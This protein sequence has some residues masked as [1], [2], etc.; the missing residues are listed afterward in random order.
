MANRQLSKKETEELF[1]PLYQ[2]VTTRLQELSGNDAGLLWALRRKLAKSLIYDE[3]GTPMQRRRLKLLK[4]EEQQG[5]CAV[6][7]ESLPERDAILDRFEAMRGYTLENTRVLCRDCDL[8]I[9]TERN[10]S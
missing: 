2:L 3:R 1:R 6:C 9:Q 7:R 4:R 8:R 10:F 5:L